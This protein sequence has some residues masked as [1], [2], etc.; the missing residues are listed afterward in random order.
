MRMG[1]PKLLTSDNGSEFRNDLEMRLAKAL[2]VKRIYTTPYHPQV[3]QYLSAHFTISLF[4]T[5]TVILLCFLYYINQFFS[6]YSLTA[7]AR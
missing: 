7:P 1:I 6:T 4:L 5:C 3:S 2:G